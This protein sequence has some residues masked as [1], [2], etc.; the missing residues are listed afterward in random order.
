MTGLD[1]TVLVQLA[2]VGHGDHGRAEAFFQAEAAAGNNLLLTPQVIAEFLHLITDTRRFERAVSMVAALDW[3]DDFLTNPSVELLMPTDESLLLANQ[4]MRKFQLGRKRV[5]D[6]QL[7][8]TVYT[9]G[10][11]R[12]LTSNPDDFK[13]FGVFDL[14]GP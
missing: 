8:A 12:L 4:W 5:L 14:I 1:T 13:I 3:V 11:R 10:A 7:A 2:D 6:T 9:A